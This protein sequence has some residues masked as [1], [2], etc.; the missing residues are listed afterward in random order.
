MASKSHRPHNV[1]SVR[2]KHQKLRQKTKQMHH[3]QKM[4]HTARPTHSTTTFSFG[5]A[6]LFFQPSLQVRPGPWRCHKQ[7]PLW[8]AAVKRSTGHV[9]LL[10][11]HSTHTVTALN[12]GHSRV[13]MVCVYVTHLHSVAPARRCHGN[14]VWLAAHCDLSV[15]VATDHHRQPCQIST[16]DTTHKYN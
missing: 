4:F 16:S 7:Q 5:L 10:T 11:S 8:I 15:A 3:I 13:N 14:A 2:N 1:S 6:G 9:S 12:T